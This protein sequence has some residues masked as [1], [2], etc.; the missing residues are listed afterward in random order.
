MPVG[1]SDPS[2]QVDAQWARV[3]ASNSRP[4]PRR[5]LQIRRS[6]RVRAPSSLASTGAARPI[7]ATT[8]TR[9]TTVA[10]IRTTR[11]SASTRIRPTLAPRDRAEVCPSCMTCSGRINRIINT[12]STSTRGQSSING[13][14]LFWTSEITSPIASN[15]P[16]TATRSGLKASNP[17]KNMVATVIPN[18]P[19]ASTPRVVGEAR[20]L[21]RI[22]WVTAPARPRPQPMRTA[23][24]TRGAQL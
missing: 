22:C 17:G 11:N 4:A 2:P 1:T 20:G 5:L 10:L 24:A 21:P 15:P 16:E 13:C 23:M 14:Q 12:P 19:P 8:P 3:S 18:W 6:D 9:L 7:K